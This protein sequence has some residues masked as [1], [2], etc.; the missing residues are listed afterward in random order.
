MIRAFH[1][2][3]LRFPLTRDGTWRTP[4][5]FAIGRGRARTKTIYLYNDQ[6]ATIV[7][8][9]LPPTTQKFVVN[10]PTSISVPPGV[11]P[12]PIEVAGDSA[13]LPWAEDFVLRF[14]R[15]GNEPPGG[16]TDTDFSSWDAYSGDVAYSE[17][18]AARFEVSAFVLDTGDPR[19]DPVVKSHVDSAR[20]F[21]QYL[22]S[23]MG[24]WSEDYRKTRVR[25]AA[26][27]LHEFALWALNKQHLFNPL[28][29]PLRHAA[30]RAEVIGY[31]PPGIAQFPPAVRRRVLAAAFPIT[32]NLGS[33]EGLRLAFEALGV[34]LAGIEVH[35]D[36]LNHLW[37]IRLPR[38]AQSIFNIDYLGTFALYHVDA[39]SVI[40]LGLRE[41]YDSIIYSNIDYTATPVDAPLAPILGHHP[42][43]RV[44][45]TSAATGTVFGQPLT[46]TVDSPAEG[47]E[48]HEGANQPP[49]LIVARPVDGEQFVDTPAPEPDPDAQYTT[50][51]YQADTT[52]ILQNPER[53][54]HGT[55]E[56][57]S[58]FVGVRNSGQTLSRWL[59]RLDSFRN[60]AISSSWLNT[61]R[62]DLQA[63]QDAG[64]KLV[65][66]YVYNY[67]WVDPDAP[68]SR[69]LG[70]IEQLS[71]IWHEY[72]GVIA[73]LQAGF[74]G[75]WGEWHSSTNGL[76]GADPSGRNQI[77][78]ALL[79]ALPDSRMLHLRYPDTGHIEFF[80]DAN[81]PLAR[82][83][84]FT[85]TDRARLGILND[86]FLAN[87][88]DGGTFVMNRYTAD[89]RFNNATKNYWRAIAPFVANSGETV[90]L[91][92]RDG[93]R[94]A[95][96]A[97]MAEM[98][99][100]AWDQLN[101]DYST[102]V[103]NNWINT[104]YYDEI[105]RRLGYRLR[106]VEARLP[107][108]ATPGARVQVELEIAN[109]GWGKVYNP[110]PLDLILAPASGPAQRVRLL[111]D[112]RRSLPL[113][114][115]TAT[116][117]M[118]FDAPAAEGEYA[119]SLALPD[120]SPSI[121]GD[122]RFAIR[123]ANTGIWD[124]GAHD[125]GVTLTV[126][127]EG[128]DPDPG[129]DTPP[130]LT[131]SRPAEGEQFTEEPGPDSPPSLTVDQPTE[132]EEFIDT[133]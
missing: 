81:T 119:L 32:R 13:D 11:T 88:T 41:D 132:D 122:A 79:D 39:Y 18:E 83:D 36:S 9:P 75:A 105:S 21:E 93:N 89:Y 49:V 104:G 58:N 34:N 77:I 71:P 7:M 126:S 118:E 103:I 114:G 133:D 45:A 35:H 47:Q 53:G 67:N 64:I 48:F 44:F 84:R 95:G 30:S 109:D 29:G 107:V 70:H 25:F 56:H 46:L 124:S 20:T 82:E 33:E 106:L 62:A 74:I 102:R 57:R 8:S 38:Y 31:A 110:R 111:Q 37:R 66:R 65:I 80:G 78:R 2:P 90:D 85:E 19:F 63:A 5:E 99:E 130:A 6:P 61:H 50:Q 100:F 125:L 15:E 4:L 52:T 60:S 3:D 87:Q 28:Y 96:P 73:S 117:L 97:A 14:V 123:L 42:S 1:D 120:A 129:P 112:A 51:Q 22:A 92:W 121:A 54:W 27:Q 86:S 108:Q 59:G 113:G 40:D 127:G 68:L 69:I 76:T 12:L 115:E 116:I 43:G 131:V 24:S 16:F 94:E 91:D 98:A 26:E 55:V 101:R 128:P 10:L 72:E 17:V 23:G